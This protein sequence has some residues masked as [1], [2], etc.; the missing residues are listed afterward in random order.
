MASSFQLALSL[1]LF[2][3]TVRTSSVLR[4]DVEP[5]VHITLATV[6]MFNLDSVRNTHSSHT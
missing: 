2:I 6:K 4:N 1:V 5:E 3:H